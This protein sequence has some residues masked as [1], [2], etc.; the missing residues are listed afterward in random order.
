MTPVLALFKLLFIDKI[1]TMKRN[2]T[3]CTLVKMYKMFREKREE[4]KYIFFWTHFRFWY[5]ILKIDFLCISYKVSRT[6][7]VY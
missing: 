2:H 5:K 4:K 7:A 6:L 3:W 1:A